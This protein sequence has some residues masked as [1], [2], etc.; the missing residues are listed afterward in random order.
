[1]MI[2]APAWGLPR[3]KQLQFC[4]CPQLFGCCLDVVHGGGGPT[5]AGPSRRTVTIAPP[6]VTFFHFCFTGGYRSIMG[7]INIIATILQPARPGMTLMKLPLF[8]L[9]L[10]IH[11][12]PAVAE[13]R[14]AG[15]DLML[16]GHPTSVQF[17][18][19]CRWR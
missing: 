15:G 11:R 17:L 18:Q 2:G 4:C 14:I 9:G 5:S 13:C 6:S 16:I 1:M 19:R 7:A 12:I 8:V 10:V 3:M